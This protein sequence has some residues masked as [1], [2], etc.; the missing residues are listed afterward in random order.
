M[1]DSDT[2]SAAKTV[3][4]EESDDE[5]KVRKQAIGTLSTIGGLAL[6]VLATELPVVREHSLLAVSAM[7]AVVFVAMAAVSKARGR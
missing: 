1:T 4:E 7:M 5:S 3:D 2:H 6:V